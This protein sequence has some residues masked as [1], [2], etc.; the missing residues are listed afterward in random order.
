MIVGFFI[1][2]NVKKYKFYVLLMNELVSYTQ[3]SILLPK[4]HLNYCISIYFIIK[5]FNQKGLFY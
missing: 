1:S 3:F 4:K 5:H 2:Q